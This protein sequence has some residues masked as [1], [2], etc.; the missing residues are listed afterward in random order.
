MSTAILRARAAFIAAIA[1][2]GTPVERRR[3]TRCRRSRR[4]RRPRPRA[5][6]ASASSPSSRCRR[7]S[8]RRPSARAPPASRAA[9]PRIFARRRRQQHP[10]RDPARARW[11]ATTN[12]SPP[13]EPGATDDRDVPRRAAAA[14]QLAPDDLGDS[15]VR[16]SPSA[17]GSERRAGSVAAASA[18]RISAA[19]S[20]G[21]KSRTPP[22]P[23]AMASRSSID[24]GAHADHHRARDQAVADV[25]LLEP[26]QRRHRP[27]VARSRGR[28]PRRGAAPRPPRARRQ[29]EPLQLLAPPRRSRAGAWQ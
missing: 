28:A 9:S 2:A 11:R 21:G 14:A 24:R 15:R 25:Q 18:A 20:S 5:S 3:E 23:A 17:A 12:P 1:A 19:V 6:R 26:G 4:R 10:D 27:D 7:R 8:A 22:R 29:L 13:F 16:R